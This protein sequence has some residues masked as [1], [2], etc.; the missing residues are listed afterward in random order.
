[1]ERFLVIPGEGKQMGGLLPKIR[2]ALIWEK[3]ELLRI[4]PIQ[5]NN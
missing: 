3:R 2:F 1:M 4:T 5:P